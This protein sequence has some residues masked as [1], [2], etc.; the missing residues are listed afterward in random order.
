[1]KPLLRSLGLLLSLHT[2]SHAAS[3]VIPPNFNGITLGTGGDNG[4]APSGIP[5]STVATGASL[6]IRSS[7]TQN[8]AVGAVAYYNVNT[9]QLSIDPKGWNIS[10]FNFTRTT[11]TVN[12][13]GSTRGP[14]T[15]ASGT[16]PTSATV[17]G[18]TGEAN[19]RTLPAGTWTLLTVAPAR[20]AGTVSLVRVPTLATTYDPGNG[21]GAASGAYT[22]NPVGD[23]I[24]PGWFTQPW[25]FPE[26]MVSETYTD[27][28]NV[29]QTMFYPNGN[30]PAD[31]TANWKVF[32]VSGNANA[33]VLGFGNYRSTFQYTV[34]GVTGNQVGAVIP[35]STVPEPAAFTTLAL[36]ALGFCMRRR[37]AK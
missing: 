7:G 25:S 33:N 6:P 15:Y 2:L 20:I 32:G 24:T 21:A 35:Y 27:Q 34:D 18:A 37:R 36:G 3:F 19:Q 26:A 8:G 29:V 13:S 14:L 9:G 22:T 1:M 31:L 23:A 17:S 11:G 5:W 30:A 10:L 12:T 4:L 16:S 28:F